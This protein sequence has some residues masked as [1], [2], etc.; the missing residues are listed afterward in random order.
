MELGWKWMIPLAL[1]NIV[2]TAIVVL[3]VRNGGA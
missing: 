3:L 2:V 1:V